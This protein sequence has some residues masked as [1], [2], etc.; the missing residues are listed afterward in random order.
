MSYRENQ[1][2]LTTTRIPLLRRFGLWLNPQRWRHARKVRGGHWVRYSNV[3]VKNEYG[4]EIKSDF[5]HSYEWLRVTEQ[6]TG[7]AS[8]HSRRTDKNGLI[9]QATDHEHH[10]EV[11]A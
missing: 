4:R 2:T 9:W 8:E 5:Y 1:Y 11:S 10:G 6:C 3:L 7:L